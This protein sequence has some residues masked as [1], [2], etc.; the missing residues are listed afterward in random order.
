MHIDIYERY[1]YIYIYDISIDCLSAYALSWPPAPRITGYKGQDNALLGVC[2]SKISSEVVEIRV[3]ALEIPENV[4]VK[5]RH[6]VKN[7]KIRWCLFA[8]VFVC[9]SEKLESG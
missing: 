6:T 3:F 1:L 9:R 7:K 2:E 5:N 8:C 4:C